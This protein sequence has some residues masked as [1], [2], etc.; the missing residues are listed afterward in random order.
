MMKYLITK[1][2][3]N[4]NLV[5]NKVKKSKLRGKIKKLTKNQKKL[6]KT[7]VSSNINNKFSI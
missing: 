3:N 5:I 6:S 7:L 1:V 4:S 2:N